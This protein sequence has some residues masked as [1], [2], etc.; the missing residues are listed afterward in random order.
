METVDDKRFIY[1]FG[2][3]VLDPQEKTLF[4]DGAP[5]HLPAKEYETLLLL[6]ENNGKALSK[7]EII[8][9]VWHDTFVEEGNLAKQISRLRKIFNSGGEQFIET[10]PK[11]G[12]RFSADVE[13]IFQPDAETIL[14]KRTVKRLTVRFENEIEDAPRTL[15]PAKKR[16]FT[17]PVLI[18][19]CSI[20]LLAAVA[21]VWLWENARTRAAKIN[22]MAVLPLKSLTGE[23]TGKALGWGLADALITKIGSLR[24][25]AV[26]PTSS[27][28]KFAAGDADALEIGKYLNVDAVLEGTIQQSDGRIRLNVR[29]LRVEN[30]EQ[31]WAETFDAEA[32]KI[33]DLEDRLSEQTARALGLK[34]GVR[35][36]EHLTKRF[37]T[38]PEAFDAYLKGRYFWNK[39]SEE[40]FRK[41][42]EYFN[43]AVEKDPNYALAYSGLADCYILLG[44]WGAEMPKEVFPQAKQYAERALQ[45]DSGLAEA[46]VSR[47]FVE[48][49]YDWDFGRADADFSRA[50][51]LNPNYPT[52]HHWYSYFLVSQGRASQAIAEIKKARELEGPLNIGVNTDIGEIYSWAGKYGEAE[53]Y[54]REV[55]KI[56]PNYAVAH[57]VL[58]INLLKQNRVSEA[59]AE[60][61][62]AQRLESEPRVLAVLVYAYA[63]GGE[64][65]KA[66]KV[67]DELDKLSKQ[68]YVSPFSKAIARIGLGETDAAMDELE[69]AYD[70]RSDTMAIIGIYPL[71][72][73]LRANP[74]FVKLEQQVNQ[75]AR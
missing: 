14:E 33:F 30:G 29:L 9:A 27:V 53:P 47:A 28:A 43:Q 12:Y 35:D 52:A 24:T 11:H 23:E 18:T 37:T 25:V 8:S 54:L 4:S 49:V 31:I 26:R 59:I 21:G 46:L 22:S 68:K 34:L 67:L 74:R 65:E 41:A 72:D 5:L 58:A 40:D 69:K 63:A 60:E 15:P 61:E 7:E 38:N 6:V 55:L 45:I 70:E 66:L 44:V 50:I 3:F 1:E 39:R 64:R 19:F 48:W 57:H 51:E 10:L 75:M 36:G 62:T 2:K 32:T 73:S 42:I 13:Q 20:V 71:L 17:T 56:E 16:I